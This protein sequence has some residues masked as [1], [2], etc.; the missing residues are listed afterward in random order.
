MSL[1]KEHL[2]RTKAGT[3]KA[4]ALNEVSRW[5]GDNTKIQGVPY[6]FV[7]HEYQPFILDAAEP[8]WVVRKCSQVG[9]TEM[10]LRMALALCGMIRGFTIAYTLPTAKF[11]STVMNTRVNPIITGSDFLSNMV[12]DID[13]TE[14]KQIGDSY[15]YLKGAASSNAPISVPCDMRIHDEVDFSDPVVLSQYQSR[16]THSK[17]KYKGQLSTPTLPKKGIDA[18]FQNSRRHFNFVKCNHCNTYFIPDYYKH[19]RVPGFT[20]DLEAIKKSN[21]HNFRYK[22]AYVECPGCG[23]KPSLQPQHRHWIWEN[24]TQNFAAFGIQVSPFDAPNIIT[25]SFLIEA[26]TQYKK[27]AD[28]VNFSL[29][30]PIEDK[31]STLT[32][33]ELEALIFSS[34]NADSGSSYVMGVD[35]GMTCWITIGAAHFD[36]S[37]RIV[38]IEGVPLAKLRERYMELRRMFRVRVTV[39]DS[40]PY[41]ETVLTLQVVDQNLFGAVYVEGR[42]GL[43]IFKVVDREEDEDKAVPE[44]RQVNIVRNKAFD[45]VMEYIRA[46]ML[47]KK[48]C[49][50]DDLWVEHLTDMRR[51][52]VF[53]NVIQELVPRWVKSSDG[54]DHLHHALLYLYIASQMMGVSHG[55]HSGLPLLSKFSTKK[56]AVV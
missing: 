11:A 20:G 47:S 25:P 53:D 39:M 16:L 2:E 26:S 48:P 7:D 27:K 49:D 55:N 14:V 15:L 56:R 34:L 13:N 24:N 8:E 32:K 44:L 1:F 45:S 40:M 28:F 12:T 9:I 54:D 19:V 18:E 10:A 52:K 38:H 30:L 36:G 3:N 29:G 43:E 35:M 46:G 33:T 22:E 50:Q 37:L 51:T 5:I 6:S 23:G 41:T 31:D 4:K 17:Y 21:L 42:K